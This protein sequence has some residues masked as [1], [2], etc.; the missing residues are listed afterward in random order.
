LSEGGCL[1]QTDTDIEFIQ[2]QSSQ[3]AQRVIE[4]ILVGRILLLGGLWNAWNEPG[5]SNK[6]V[7][8]MR[9]TSDSLIIKGKVVLLG[10][11]AFIFSG[12]AAAAPLAPLIV[13]GAIGAITAEATKPKT[14]VDTEEGKSALETRSIQLKEIDGDYKMTFRST[15]DVLQDM[16]FTIAQT[17]L[18]TGHIV[19]IKKIP[20]TTNIKTSLFTS[21]QHKSFIPQEATVTLERWREGTTRV[22]VTTD[23]GKTEGFTINLSSADKARYLQPEKFYEE[24]FANLS[25]AV[26]LRKEKI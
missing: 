16:G 23:L 20:V 2:P 24:F 4:R 5:L 25:K 21:Q 19:G 12:C 13:S 7:R 8:S 17:N 15:L 22:R 3:R 11:M 9:K 18:D 14:T 1:P 10:V 6:E 26:F